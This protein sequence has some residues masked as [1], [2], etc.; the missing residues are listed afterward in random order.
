M[1]KFAKE[2]NGMYFNEWYG[3]VTLLIAGAINEFKWSPHDFN[4]AV[5]EYGSMQELD[6]ALKT[7]SYTPNDW[8]DERDLWSQFK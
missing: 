1:P 2:N 3:E 6:D 4:M 5:Y 7:N 8:S